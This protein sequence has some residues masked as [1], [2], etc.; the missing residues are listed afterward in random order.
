M[1]AGK[2]YV[3]Y[4]TLTAVPCIILHPTI[5]FKWKA[6]LCARGSSTDGGVWART[7]GSSGGG[8]FELDGEEKSGIDQVSI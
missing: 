8:E 7:I 3:R 2:N 4:P 6:E 5:T 1:L